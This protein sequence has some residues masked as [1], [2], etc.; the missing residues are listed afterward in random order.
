[1]PK[2]AETRL[3]YKCS[4]TGGE[5]KIVHFGLIAANQV[6]TVDEAVKE[7]L[8]GESTFVT[9]RHDVKIKLID[10]YSHALGAVGETQP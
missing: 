4:V 8:A 3:A 5:L 9:C 7:L 2:G 10:S 6:R 1:M